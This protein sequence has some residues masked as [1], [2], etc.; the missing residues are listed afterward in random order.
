[1]TRQQGFAFDDPDSRTRKG[2]LNVVYAHADEVKPLDSSLFE[3]FS[4]MYALTYTSSIPM[5]TSLLR[6]YD[7]DEFECVFG[8]NGILS[9]EAAQIL[10]FQAVMDE[11]LSKGFL[12]LKGLS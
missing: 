2:V 11:K 5:I 9:H 4:S 10:S 6:D 3:N 8:H 12:G 1:M 7:F